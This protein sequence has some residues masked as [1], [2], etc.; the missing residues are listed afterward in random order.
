MALAATALVVAILVGIGL[1][2]RPP[3]V[4][5]PPAPSLTD[6]AAPEASL[7]ALGLPGARTAPAGQYGWTGSLGA[8]TGLHSVIGNP[9]SPDAFRQTQLTFAVADDCFAYG[10]DVVPQPVTVAG[11]EGTY[12]EPYE[13]PAVMFMPPPRGSAATGAYALAVG[14]RTLCVYLT[15]DLDTAQAELEAARQV[16]ESLRAQPFGPDGVRINFTLPDGW[17]TG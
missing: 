14:D 12:V 15:W 11:L 17:D 5:P 10:T 3:N 4:G 2:A 7:A 9:G 1:L 16:V 6:T 8:S 13:D